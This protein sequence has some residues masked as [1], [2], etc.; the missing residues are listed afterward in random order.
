MYI[1][2]KCTWA[3]GVVKSYIFCLACSKALELTLSTTSNNKKNIAAIMWNYIHSKHYAY[4]Q[5]DL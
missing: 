2:Q 1:N 4:P 3:E 5:K